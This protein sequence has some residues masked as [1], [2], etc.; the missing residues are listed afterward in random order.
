MTVINPVAL[1]QALVRC[2]SVT[3]ADG[4][5]LSEVQLAAERLGFTCERV[6]FSEPGHADIDNLYARLGGTGPNFCFAGHTDVVPVGDAGA[7]QHDPFGATIEDGLL[8]GRGAADMKSAVAAFLA[9]VERFLEQRA[10]G[11]DG[12]ITL[13]ITGDEEADSVN[14]T[15]KLLQWLADR[16]ETLDAALVG[17]PTSPDRLGEMVKIGRRGSMSGWVT[18]NGIQGHTAYPPPRRQPGQPA[19]HHAGR[20][21]RISARRWKRAFRTEQPGNHH[22]R[23]RQSGQQRYPGAGFGGLQHPLQRPA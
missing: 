18:V 12:S 23:Y 19:G 15:V 11:F 8:Y 20:A 6:T 13:L 2:P 10:G 4:G 21:D 22:H 3:P 16:G 9:A 14:G 7:W 1:T 17:E 5:A